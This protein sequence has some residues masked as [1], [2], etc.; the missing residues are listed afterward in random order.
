LIKSFAKSFPLVFAP[1][2]PHPPAGQIIAEP[3]LLHAQLK[4]NSRHC[5]FFDRMH[6]K[7]KR[8]F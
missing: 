3:W 8:R 1:F 4:P 6:W 2:F 7:F 5:S